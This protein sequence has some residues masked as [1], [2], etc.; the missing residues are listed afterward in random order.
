LK[1]ILLALGGTVVYLGLATLVLRVTST[2]R[3]AAALL[4]LFLGTLPVLLV[5]HALTP[6]DLGILPADFTEGNP[7]IDRAVSLYLYAAAFF[8]GSLQ[9]YNLAERGFSLRILIDV[10]ESP[11]GEMTKEQIFRSY[12]GGRGIEWMYQKRIDGLREQLLIEPD[13]SRLRTTRRGD[14]TAAL[15][16]RLRALFRLGLWT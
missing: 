1:G 11:S 14:R 8:G 10:L 6:P 3:R 7:W 9:L 5:V 15:F 16:K 13:A 4:Y 12:G 2:P